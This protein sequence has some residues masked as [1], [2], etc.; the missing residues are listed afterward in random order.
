MDYQCGKIIAKG[1]EGTIYEVLGHSELLIKIY[2]NNVVTPE[3]QHKIEFMKN[4]PPTSLVKKG[5]LAWPI[6][7]IYSQGKLIGFVMPKLISDASLLEIYTYRHPLIDKEYSKFPPVQSRIGIAMNL[8]YIVSELHKAG[9]VIGDMNHENIGINK[10]NAQVQIFD[11]DSFTVTDNVGNVLRTNVCMKGYLAPEIIKHCNSERAKGNPYNLDAVALPTFTRESDL[12]CL[13]VHIFQLLMNGIHPFKGVI[14]NASGSNAAPFPGNEGIERNNYVFKQGFYAKA[15][16]CLKQNE[17]PAGIKSLFDRAFLDGDSNPKRRPTAEE[18]YITLTDYLK[19][20][21]QCVKN[22]NHQF[23]NKLSS[24]PYCEADERFY[25]DQTGT[26]Q[27]TSS[28]NNQ[29]VPQPIVPKTFGNT[30]QT[31][32]QW[33]NTQQQVQSPQ[34][35]TNG[36]E[37]LKSFIEWVKIIGGIAC[38]IVLCVGCWWIESLPNKN[39]A[40]Q[41][42]ASYSLETQKTVQTEKSNSSDTKK[43]FVTTLTALPNE[44][45]SVAKY[46]HTNGLNARTGPD[47]N[48]N[49]MFSLSKDS[50]VYVSDISKNGVWV[51]IKYNNKIGWVN[52]SYL[53]DF[54]IKSF[55]I[56][57]HNGIDKWISYPDTELYASKIN[58]LRIIFDVETVN[59]YNETTKFYI[60]MVTPENKYIQEKNV[61]PGFV[62]EVKGKLESGSYWIDVENVVPSYYAKHPGTW[63]IQMYYKNPINPNTMD[64]IGSKYIELK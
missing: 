55:K 10:T 16:M 28:F 61:H 51:K 64:C 13:S 54:V 38:S 50:L 49:T 57:N 41:E 56:G 53:R 12:F 34:K 1:G 9:Y 32:N 60:K 15:L 39:S 6:D 29:P 58:R 24:C 19:S 48:Y 45:F 22:T 33:Q 63:L 46:V 8:S 44:K 3:L 47:V 36:K 23:Y 62:K 2:R 31:N 14:N 5:C 26:S 40:T 43:E 17:I 42:T 37:K 52:G 59:N 27:P 11:C 30:S 25:V 4:N 20:L 7:I 21:K 18:W 35:F